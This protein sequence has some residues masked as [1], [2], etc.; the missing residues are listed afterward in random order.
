MTVRYRLLVACGLSLLSLS[1]W[2]A[3]WTAQLDRTEISEQESVNL[4]LTLDDH[5]ASQPDLS[6]LERDFEILNQSSRQNFSSI[7]GQAQSQSLWD[8]QLVPRHSGELQ[9]PPISLGSL[10]TEAVPIRV[11]A[12][13]EAPASATNPLQIALTAPEQG[14]PEQPLKLSLRLT[15]DLSC[16][17][18]TD[19]PPTPVVP[20]SAKLSVLGEPRSFQKRIGHGEFLVYEQDYLLSASRSGPLELEP[21]SFR[22]Q[23]LCPD[24]DRAK[25]HRVQ[26]PLTRIQILDKPADYQ[27]WWLPTDSL[28]LSEDFAKGPYKVGEPINR[29]IRLTATGVTAEQ[30]PEVPR[31]SLPN[32]KIYADPPQ[33]DTQRDRQQLQASREEQLSL[34]PTQAGKLELPAIRIAF[35]NTRTGKT[36]MAELPARQLDILDPNPQPSVAAPSA[37]QTD[38]SGSTSTAPAIVTPWWASSFSL[39]GLATLLV[40]SNL[41][42]LWWFR[43]QA[44]ALPVP[45]GQLPSPELLW[46]EFKRACQTH[47]PMAAA[48][49]LRSLLFY[50]QQRRDLLSWSQTLSADLAQQL[51]QLDRASCQPQDWNGRELLQ[52]LPALEAA[53]AA[54][55]TPD[56]QSSLN[57]R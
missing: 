20:A 47:Q 45:A 49:S 28:S 1:G 7:N 32:L 39:I 48:Q 15:L 14:W 6:P 13:H 56:P 25:L 54:S 26:T 9:I 34:L 5:S 51:A 11:L 22:A 10:T 52:Q 27:G 21:I 2:A 8:I 24:S 16:Q 40:L 12:S 19:P 46:R 30:L 29:K 38:H 33:L 35:F 57:P 42:W 3:S 37:P 18:Q 31:T 43:R 55:S 4:R 23:M 41:G 53:L 36:D 17:R 50:Y 44:T